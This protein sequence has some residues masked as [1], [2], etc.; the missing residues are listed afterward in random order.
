MIRLLIVI[1]SV[2]TL[3]SYALL[4][5]D[6]NKKTVPADVHLDHPDHVP[7]NGGKDPIKKGHTR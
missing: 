1:C 7:H 3:N 2:F 5:G 6:S 4:S